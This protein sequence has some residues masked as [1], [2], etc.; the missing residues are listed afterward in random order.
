M[1]SIVQAA[2]LGLAISLL[3]VRAHAQIFSAAADFSTATNT[4]TSRWSY[5]Y[6]TTGTRDGNY[7]L[8]PTSEP[9]DAT[10]FNWGKPFVP[11]RW[12]P[13]PADVCPCI[14]P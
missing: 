2:T 5:R 4:D 1:T 10:W 9:T 8:L 12:L 14:G 6:N 7:T 13:Q 11:N 3:T